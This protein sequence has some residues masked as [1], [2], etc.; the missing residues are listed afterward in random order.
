MRRGLA[1]FWDEEVLLEVVSFSQF[2]IHNK[3]QEHKADTIFL[4][5]GFYG[6]LC[7]N[8]MMDSWELLARFYQKVTLSWCFFDD[9]NEIIT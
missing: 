4:I 9:F 6:I 5:T 1:L 3:V 2:H 8:K 7:T